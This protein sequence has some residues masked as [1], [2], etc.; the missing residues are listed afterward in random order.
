MM[1]SNIGTFA[2]TVLSHSLG[3]DRD[4]CPRKA[5]LKH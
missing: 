2:T 5:W 3:E 1:A 4:I